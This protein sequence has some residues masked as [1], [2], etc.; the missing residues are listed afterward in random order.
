MEIIFFYVD[1]ALEEIQIKNNGLPESG[2]L[3]LKPIQY[4]VMKNL[5]NNIEKIK[6]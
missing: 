6:K 2:V 3:I 4:L 5:I 1:D